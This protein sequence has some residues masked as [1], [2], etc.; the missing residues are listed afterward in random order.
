MNR[1]YRIEP[2]ATRVLHPSARRRARRC[3]LSLRAEQIG[4]AETYGFDSA[5]VAQHHFHADRRRSAGATRLPG[6]CRRADLADPP[7]HRRHHAAARKSGTGRRGC[8]GARSA[9]SAGG[10]K[11]ASAPAVR[12][13]R[14]LRSASRAPS[15]ADIFAEHLAS[16]VDAWAG[17]ALGGRRPALS[18]GAATA[19]PRLAGDV[20]RAGGERAGRAGDGLMLSRTQPRTEDAP[21]ASLAEI[22]AT[23]SSTPISRHC[24]QAARR[25]SSVHVACSSRTAARRRFAWPRRPAPRARAASS[26]PATSRRA[27]SLAD[28]IAAFDVHVG[29]P[30]DVID[31]LRADT[32]L[33]RVTDLVFQVHSI[34]PP[35]PL[36]LRSI[37]L[38]ATEVAPALGW[39]PEEKFAPRRLGAVG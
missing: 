21:H 27:T 17:R 3:A 9:L 2:Q 23:R 6:A 15:R 18:G 39:A 36:I 20:L 24:R 8:G 38:I 4:H 5:W 25:G 32:T 30:D 29:T 19:R 22:A 13:H 10:S 16:F 11:S 33:D 31:S 1:T 7:R 34:D 28:L 14:S 12:R 37:E 26:Q 35:H